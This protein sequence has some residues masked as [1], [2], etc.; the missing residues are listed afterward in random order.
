MLATGYGEWK[1][2]LIDIAV[3]SV[4]R[5]FEVENLTWGDVLKSFKPR[6]GGAEAEEEERWRLGAAHRNQL[7]DIGAE[8]CP[9]GSW[10]IIIG[11]PRQDEKCW[12][13]SAG[14]SGPRRVA[15]I[16][17]TDVESCAAGW[18]ETRVGGK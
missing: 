16:F 18:T 15:M 14:E 8:G 11:M 7:A 1:A 12:L 5:T 2:K 13:R 10:E 3:E 4:I 17:D 6:V 9:E